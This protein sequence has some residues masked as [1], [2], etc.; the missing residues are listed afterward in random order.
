[1]PINIH[2]DA[3]QPLEALFAECSRIGFGVFDPKSRFAGR[4][5][6]CRVEEGGFSLYTAYHR[7]STHGAL[8]LR[9]LFEPIFGGETSSQIPREDDL[10]P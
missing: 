1:M 10:D 7:L 8:L 3:S 4:T 6:R 9:P 5:G 2:K